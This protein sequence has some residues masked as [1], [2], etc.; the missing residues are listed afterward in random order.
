MQ[1]I[2]ALLH[3]VS[4]PYSC[5]VLH[6]FLSDAVPYLL[7]RRAAGAFLLAGAYMFCLHHATRGT[8]ELFGVSLVCAFSV[9]GRNAARLFAGSG[10]GLN[11]PVHIL[12]GRLNAGY[13]NVG[14]HASPVCGTTCR[15]SLQF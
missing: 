5:A 3:D 13:L 6:M 12:L 15:G 14:I 2:R 8:P 4:T 1:R 7:V 9:S 11:V 10:D